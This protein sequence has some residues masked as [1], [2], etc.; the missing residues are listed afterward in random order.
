MAE[1]QV[2]E[3]PYLD[4]THNQLSV[5]VG[6]VEAI[7]RVYREWTVQQYCTGNSFNSWKDQICVLFE[8]AGLMDLVEEIH[9]VPPLED[10]EGML[11]GARNL[12]AKRHELYN[13]K[14]CLV[15]SILMRSIVDTNTGAADKGDAKQNQGLAFWKNLS[16]Q[17]ER[18]ET[19]A[20]VMSLKRA[21]FILKQ[22]SKKEDVTT[23]V[24][25]I[26]RARDLLIKNRQPI[27][28]TDAKGTLL[29]GIIDPG[30]GAR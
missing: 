30:E 25:R 27:S 7:R 18:T 6:Q 28:E 22:Y 15:Y 11:I 19:S 23:F 12:Q 29:E 4:M 3:D 1:A 5:K 26:D 17:N 13:L 2:P 9:R 14:N 16:N 8:D 24:N 10:V 21:F 20:D